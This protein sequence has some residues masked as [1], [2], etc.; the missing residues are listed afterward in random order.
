MTEVAVEPN[1]TMEQVYSIFVAPK[2]WRK[3]CCFPHEVLLV[4]RVLL[5]T[6]GPC[7]NMMFDWFTEIGIGCYDTQN[8]LY[9]TQNFGS[10]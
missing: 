10:R 3:T 2:W 4:A 1:K 5:D 8:Y 9:W 6:V 7:S